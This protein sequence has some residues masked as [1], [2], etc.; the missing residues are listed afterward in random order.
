MDNTSYSTAGFRKQTLQQALDSIQK[1][2]FPA[3]EIG[4]NPHANNPF[5]N[6]A[7]TEF[8]KELDSRN[9]KPRSIHAPSG[10]TTLGATTEE[11]RIKEMKTLESFIIF[12]SDIEASDMVIHPIPNPI[13]VPDADNPNNPEIM[14]KAVARSLDYLIPIAE[15]Y[16]I[17]MNLENLP[18]HCN[19]PYRSMKEL[20]LLVNQYPANQLGLI[21]DTGHV[22]VMGNEIV[23]EIKSAGERLK[24]THLHDVNGNQDGDDHKG[25]NRGL[26]NWDDMLETLI[27]INYSGPY[28]FETIVTKENETEEELAIFTRTFAKT[29][30]S[31]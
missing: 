21:L 19:Y 25:P 5:K 1:A 31:I 15:K 30:L 11:W 9:L 17:R 20:R 23:E 27:E 6:A 22:G 12:A 10:L 26:L 7:L 14:K 3:V 16:G 18:Y 4:C 28:T 2:G 24:G 13:F 8:T 29:W